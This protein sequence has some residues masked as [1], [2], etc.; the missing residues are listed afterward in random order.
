MDRRVQVQV[1]FAG[2]RELS[3]A[4]ILRWQGI[5]Q[6]WFTKFYWNSP[7]A[8]DHVDDMSNT[9][10]FV[11]QRVEGSD[12]I[13]TYDQDLNY[14]LQDT[15][16][17][18]TP[19]MVARLPFQDEKANND[20]QEQLRSSFDNFFDVRTPVVS[21]SQNQANQD[22]ESFPIGGIIGIAAGAGLLV[23]GALYVGFARGRGKRQDH[24]SATTGGPSTFIVAD[25]QQDVSTM[26]DP[27]LLLDVRP[28][29]DDPAYGGYNKSAGYSGS[30][31]Y[32]SGSGFQ[33]TSLGK[34][35]AAG[36]GDG[37]SLTD[38]GGTQR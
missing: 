4:N 30:A 10:T 13:V 15:P 8:D 11:S 19:D 23:A 31:G 28:A 21:S 22:G 3:E 38:G 1:K 37:G 32:H 7:N 14:I 26:E 9:V 6:E 25:D 27:T 17:A 20:Y 33:S 36:Y 5:T 18:P 24:T 35:D 2:A 29:A 16:T 12:I 34:G